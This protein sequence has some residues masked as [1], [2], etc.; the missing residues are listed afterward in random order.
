M[1]IICGY[2][3]VSISASRFNNTRFINLESSSF[4][5]NGVRHED[6]Y[7]VYCRIAE[8]LSSQGFHVFVSS[9]KSVRDFLLN[10]SKEKLI[11]V[12]PSKDIKRDWIIKLSNRYAKTKD[13][14]DYE[15]FSDAVYHFD[16]QVEDLDNQKG[17][18]KVVLKSANEYNL[19]TFILKA[20]RDLD[21]F[22]IPKS[23]KNCSHKSV[24]SGVNDSSLFKNINEAVSKLGCKD[25]IDYNKVYIVV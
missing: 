6:W 7:K 25:F 2:H 5:I 3:G 4:F 18:S 19:Y 20:I 13:Q 14:K 22:D 10:N 16:E 9:Q 21:S 23:C 8:K 12:Y 24:C 15:D 1:A 11:L 17:F